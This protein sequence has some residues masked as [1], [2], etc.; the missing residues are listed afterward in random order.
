[1][2]GG[3]SIIAKIKV[4]TEKAIS[5]IKDWFGENAKIWV[6]DETIYASFKCNE[7]AFYYWIMQYAEHFEVISPD[8]IKEKIK[9]TITALSEI[10]K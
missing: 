4:K 6:E 3:P 7:Q 10:Y 1:M 9:K 2:F 5:F 8:S